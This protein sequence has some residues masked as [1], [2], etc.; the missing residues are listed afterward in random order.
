MIGDRL[1]GARALAAAA[2]AIGVTALTLAPA[3]AHSELASS[4]PADGAELASA[5]RRVV[6][7]FNEDVQ[8]TGTAV[9]VT[10]SSGARV[11]DEAGLRVD[12]VDVVAPL[13]P[14]TGSGEYT[15]AYRVVS[16]D[17]HVISGTLHFTVT[18][19]K[20]TSPATTAT[21]STPSATPAPTATDVTT[22]A[23]SSDAASGGSSALPWL[24]LTTVVALAGV[25]LAVVVGRA[26]RGRA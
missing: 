11:D 16:A 7:T 18:A 25:M 3:A 15:V 8:E 5:P 13:A 4:D 1:V 9:T 6:L 17:G 2:V 20:T 19:P 22:A 26:R 23:A 12:G 14:D 10:D 24:A 21:P